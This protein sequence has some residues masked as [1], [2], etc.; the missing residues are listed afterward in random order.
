M[1]KWPKE[2]EKKKVIK[3][4]E[5]LG[6]EVVR[7]GNHISMIKVNPD[8]SKIPLTM[9]NHRKIKGV[10]LRIICRQT[11]IRREDFLKVYKEI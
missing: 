4:F 2:I 7:I 1:D 10:T 5:K 11:G 8:G 6:F 3:I 9:P